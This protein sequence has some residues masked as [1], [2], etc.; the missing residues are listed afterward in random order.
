[1]PGN[2]T[3]AEIMAKIILDEANLA[4]C[5]TTERQDEPGKRTPEGSCWDQGKMEGEYDEDDF[6]KI[7]ELQAKAATV[8]DDHPELE[9]LTAEIFQSIT[10]E[11]AVEVLKKMSENK[12]ILELGR[13][14]VTVF[15]L[16]FPSPESFINK[17]HPLVMASDDYMLQNSD[18]Q[19]WYDFKNIADEFG[20]V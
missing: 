15:L 6:Q 9:D 5:E 11:N 17:G 19:N 3:S 16:R 4:F 7:L 1:M 20:W 12:E 18:A 14:S 10:S 8:C 13:V 2:E